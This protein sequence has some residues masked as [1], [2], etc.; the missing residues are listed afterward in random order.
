MEDTA[1][2]DTQTVLKQYKV[3]RIVYLRDNN[4]MYIRCVGNNWGEFEQAPHK[5]VAHLQYNNMFA[6]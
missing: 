2:Y 3:F 5:R 1:H 6:S 4:I